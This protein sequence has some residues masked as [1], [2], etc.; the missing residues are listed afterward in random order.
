MGEF[1]SCF[2]DPLPAIAHDVVAV[3]D[4]DDD[5][6]ARAADGTPSVDECAMVPREAIGAA[7]PVTSIA[8]T[9]AWA[10]PRT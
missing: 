6:F 3:A 5:W 10:T 2:G 8:V 4:G 9:V 7:T 1:D